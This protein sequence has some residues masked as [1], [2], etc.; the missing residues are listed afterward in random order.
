M[1]MSPPD[2]TQRQSA[3]QARTN[4]ATESRLNKLKASQWEDQSSRQAQIFTK[5]IELV[6]LTT[7]LALVTDKIADLWRQPNGTSAPHYYRLKATK[8]DLKQKIEALSEKIAAE[9]KAYEEERENSV[10]E[11]FLE[12]VIQNFQKLI[13]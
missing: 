10:E 1:K 2:L 8:G 6:N 11:N 9:K 12:K 7:A 13:I 5:E 4:A 3:R